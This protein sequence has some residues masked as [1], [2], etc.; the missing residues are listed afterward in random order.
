MRVVL[1]NSLINNLHKCNAK[2]VVIILQ[3]LIHLLSGIVK[4]EK[5]SDKGKTGESRR[6]K[7]MGL[8]SQKVT[9]TARP[10]KITNCF[11]FLFGLAYHKPGFFIRMADPPSK[12]CFTSA[13][14][15]RVGFAKR[16]KPCS[17]T[18]KFY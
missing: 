16:R 3:G 1:C 14:P 2:P 15:M 4:L 18:S 13:N 5:T 7:A 6:R 10:P 12:F 11:L 8:P 9:M 17:V